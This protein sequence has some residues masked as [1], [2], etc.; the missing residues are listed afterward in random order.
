MFFSIDLKTLLDKTDIKN[1]PKPFILVSHSM[2]GTIGLRTLVGRNHPFS[3]A[4]FSAPAWGAKIFENAVLNLIKGLAPVSKNPGIAKIKLSPGGKM[5]YVLLSSA[6]ENSLTSDEKQ[7]KRLQEI[8][9]SEPKLLV[10]PPTVGWGLAAAEELEK[11][12][13]AKPPT[14]P[15]LIFMSAEE[16]VVDNEAIK[17]FAEKSVNSKLVEINKARHEVFLETPKIQQTVWIHIDDFLSKLITLTP[18]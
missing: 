16:T 1:L 10:G 18:R 6:S 14:I 8:V 9:R 17:R 7:F 3:A 12:T 11:L 2:G 4:I 13:K 5:P 15:I